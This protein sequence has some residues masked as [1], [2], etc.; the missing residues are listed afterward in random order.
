MLWKPHEYKVNQT[1]V[2]SLREGAWGIGSQACTGMLE[3]SGIQII[4]LL[5]MALKN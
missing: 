2:V 4:K 3:S 5:F 1:H